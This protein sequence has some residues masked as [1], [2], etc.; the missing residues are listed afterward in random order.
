MFNTIYVS[1]TSLRRYVATSLRRYVATSNLT[2]TRSRVKNFIHNLNALVKEASRG[3]LW[4]FKN[5]FYSARRRVVGVYCTPAPRRAKLEGASKPARS[6]SEVFEAPQNSPTCLPLSRF[7]TFLLFFMCL[8]GQVLAATSPDV[9]ICPNG[10]TLMASEVRT[11]EDVRAF[12]RCARDFIAAKKTTASTTFA[13]PSTSPNGSTPT[14][15]A[16]MFLSI[17]TKAAAAMPSHKFT[18]TAKALKAHPSAPLSHPLA[19]T[20]AMPTG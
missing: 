15:K 5:K 8:S 19:T 9:Y 2:F 12:A 13:Q 3:V 18:P 16:R 17:K 1:L 11:P 4:S 6:L 10:K 20:S 14:D 7:M